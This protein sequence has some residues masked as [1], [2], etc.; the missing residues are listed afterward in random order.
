MKEPPLIELD[1]SWRSVFEGDSYHHNLT[2]HTEAC[3]YVWTQSEYDV[4][5]TL[6]TP[7]GATKY[8]LSITMKRDSLRVY[9]K[10]KGA[11][12]DNVL[13]RSIN[14]A[15]S[16]WALDDTELTIVLGKSE[17]KQAWQRLVVGG[18]EIGIADARRLND[19][20]GRTARSSFPLLRY[21]RSHFSPDGLVPSPHHSLPVRQWSTHRAPS[22]S[23]TKARSG[24]I[25]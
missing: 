23:S 17:K 13:N 8:D 5:V 25:G 19:S 9:I 6:K 12:I 24:T 20:D 22:T 7:P 4:T 14:L 11:V 16:T 10:G 21:L 15:E 3:P 1:H 18:P 2:T